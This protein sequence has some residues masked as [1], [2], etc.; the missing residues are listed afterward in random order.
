[1]LSSNKPILFNAP[2]EYDEVE[3]YFAHDIH[4]GSEQHDERKWAAFKREILAKPNRYVIFVGDCFEN[5][6]VN[7]KGDVFS[8]Q[9]NPHAQKEW[10]TQQLKELEGHVIAIVPGNHEARTTRMTG[11]FPLYDCACQTNLQ[12]NYRQDF[13]VVDIGVGRGHGENRQLH[14]FGY[15]VHRAKNIKSVNGSDYVDGIDFFAYGHDHDPKD[16]P[17]ARLVYDARKKVVV[18]KNIEVLNSGAFLTYGGY[19]VSGGYRPL[20]SKLY[21]LVLS[22]KGKDKTM[23]TIGFYV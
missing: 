15:I 5:V 8:Q 22:G 16:Q 10:F 13:A 18:Q 19:A 20:S 11:M 14:Y 12:N 9:Y 21:K 6:I 3:I 4:R 1:M 17:R 7:S 2:P 23:T